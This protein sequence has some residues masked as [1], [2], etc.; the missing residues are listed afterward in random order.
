[1]NT[2]TANPPAKRS[3]WQSLGLAMGAFVLVF[4]L[5]Q[6]TDSG[7]MYPFRLLVTFVHETGHG[8]TALLTGGSFNH[9]VVMDN[10]AGVA[11]TSG[12]SHILVLQMGYLGAALFGSVLLYLANRIENVK[13]LAVGVGAF[14]IICAVMYTGNGQ[15]AAIGPLILI[16]L[17]LLPLR[18]KRWRMW[19]RVLSIAVLIVT[20][21][22]IRTDTA[23][24]IGVMAGLV[25]IV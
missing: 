25:L 5:W 6:F 13:L 20:F 21:I 14:F 1:M 15:K 12:G 3:R 19:L 4:T 11:S 9:F 7:L 17:W 18:L 2:V 16:G 10:G 8:L 24:M 22:L 23:L